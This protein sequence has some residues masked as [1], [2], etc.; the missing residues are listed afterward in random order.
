MNTSYIIRLASLFIAI[1][2]SSFAVYSIFRASNISNTFPLAHE[3]RYSLSA[4]KN[5]EK[6]KKELDMIQVQVNSQSTALKST[7]PELNALEEQIAQMD[8]KLSSISKDVNI[9][10]DGV[11]Y[12][13]DKAFSLP[14]I[15]RDIDDINLRLSTMQSAIQELNSDTKSTVRWFIST[16]ISIVVSIIIFTLKPWQDKLNKNDK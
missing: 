3:Q 2:S 13:I 10:K 1:T 5:L 7:V 4:E 8:Y 11:R 15:R 16:I 14:M 6:I 9:I 12:D